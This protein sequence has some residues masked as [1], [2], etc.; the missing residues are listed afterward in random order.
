MKRE[1][2]VFNVCFSARFCLYRYA[3]KLWEATA[4]KQVSSWADC[5]TDD[6]DDFGGGG[7]APL[8]E[9]WGGKPGEEEEEEEELE[10]VEVDDM[11]GG[12][13]TSCCCTSCCVQVA[14]YKLNP[15]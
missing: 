10:Y 6:D 4:A 12:L 7:L 2:L 8:P 11:V 14:V 5:D 9:D 1:N 13:C 15:V 3:E